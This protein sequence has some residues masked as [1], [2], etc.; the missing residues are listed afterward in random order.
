[1][2]DECQDGRVTAQ[3]PA[4]EPTLRSYGGEPGDAR[5]ARRRA[6]L[7]DAALDL[8][9]D[10][11]SG[12]VTVRGICARAGLTPRY[13]YESFSGVDDLVGA[14]YDGVIAEIAETA[15][16]GLAAGE[17]TRGKVAG[18]IGAIVDV[19]DSDRRKGRLLF[20]DT[21]RSPVVAT[22]RE[23]SMR[24][25]VRLTSE[26]AAQ[27]MGVRP[28][29]ETTAAAYFQVGGMGRLLASWTAGMI[30]L[31]RDHVVEVCV[32]LMLPGGAAN[33]R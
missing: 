2:T 12:G 1:M 30:D 24:L 29:P 16:A 21:L 13:F 9:G 20:T 14:T 31:D 7:I 26:S 23:D 27:V 11:E 33:E 3:D 4:T 28:G 22:K 10:P 19:V 15:L 6:A 17:D 5:V 18:A 8:L 32:R 25:F